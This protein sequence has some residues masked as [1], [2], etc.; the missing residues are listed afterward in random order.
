MFR[1][2][3][4]NILKEEHRFKL[5]HCLFHLISNK[6]KTIRLG[7]VCVK[8]MRT[9]FDASDDVDRDIQLQLFFD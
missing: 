7:V 8:M 5:V 1:L 9:I 3:V 2:E 6:V 4:K